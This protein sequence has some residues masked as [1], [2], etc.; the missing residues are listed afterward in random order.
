MLARV[1]YQGAKEPGSVIL[2]V[3]PSV[4]GDEPLDILQYRQRRRAFPQEPTTDQYFDEAQW[5]SYRALGEHVGHQ[6]F[7]VTELTGG[8]SPSTMVRPA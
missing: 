7:R 1:Y 3:K 4:T 5:E 2:F 6:L 8:W